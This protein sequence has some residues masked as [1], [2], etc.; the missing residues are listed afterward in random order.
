MAT[1]L[2]KSDVKPTR[3]ST[4]SMR[5]FRIITMMQKEYGTFP[6]PK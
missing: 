5:G 1:G 4:G 2:H 3:S 6:T